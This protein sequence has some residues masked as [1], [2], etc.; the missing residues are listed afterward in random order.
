V[1]PIVMEM[2]ISVRKRPRQKLKLKDLPED[3][4]PRERL[5]KLGPSA[6]SNTE[7]LAIIL[8]SGTAEENVLGMS[9]QLL[10]RHNISELSRVSISQL[11]KI[12][13]IGK[14]KACQ[15]SA[16][17]E[18]GRR[19]ASHTVKR[20][21]LIKTSGDA[22]R[23]YG[24]EMKHLKKE[25]LKA[26]L[27]DSRCRLIKDETV[28]IGSLDANIV[29]P[30]EVYR[31]ALLESASYVML[32]HNHPSGDPTPTREDIEAT[33][34]LSAAGNA[35]GIPLIDHL[36]IGNGKFVSMRSAGLM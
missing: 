23:I 28:S 14:S 33:R 18:L 20:S 7:L 11:E 5:M 3:E 19:L 36:V 22:V 1:E 35:I 26:V 17:F 10:Q 29:H 8:R 15:I 21:P 30:R 24:P 4:R 32:M 27:L 12:R 34:K 25:H 31:L 16:C 2:K 9:A 6:L 13:G